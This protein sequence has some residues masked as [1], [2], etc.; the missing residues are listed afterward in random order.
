M[1]FKREEQNPFEQKKMFKKFEQH[2][3]H[4]LLEWTWEPKIFFENILCVT[5]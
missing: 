3:A 1:G 4:V 2:M 5:Q